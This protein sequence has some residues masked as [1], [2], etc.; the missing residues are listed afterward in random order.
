MN[1][2]TKMQQEAYAT[3]SV[4]HGSTVAAA[5]QKCQL[6]QMHHSHACVGIILA[7]FG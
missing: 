2:S 1:F 6:H 5:L 3:R 7:F 4:I